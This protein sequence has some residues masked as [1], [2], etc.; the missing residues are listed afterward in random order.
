VENAAGDIS[1]LLEQLRNKR[2]LSDKKVEVNLNDIIEQVMATKQYVLPVPQ[3]QTKTSSAIVSL[4]KS[5][6]SN[7]LAHLIENAQQAT[8]DDGEILLTLSESTGYYLIEIKDSGHGMDEDFI[9]NRLFK[10]FDTTKGNAG[11][12][13]GMYESREFMRQLGGDILVQS[14]SGKETII[15][16]QIPVGLTF[17]KS[18]DDEGSNK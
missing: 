7:V 15:T 17:D 11:M 6:L 8:E 4:D 3:Y 18:G 16:L 2:A 13:I 10:A 9:R 14:K 1:R 12:G 5:R